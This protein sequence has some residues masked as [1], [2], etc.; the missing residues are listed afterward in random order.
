[1]AGC[2]NLCRFWL[3]ERHRLREVVLVGK[4]ELEELDIDWSPSLA[5]LIVSD[6][7]RLRDLYLCL[8]H[9]GTTSSEDSPAPVT[10]A[11]LVIDCPSLS[12]LHLAGWHELFAG[13]MD[14]AGAGGGGGS[15]RMPAVKQLRLGLPAEARP[16]N[17]DQMRRTIRGL[18]SL[19]R[20]EVPFALPPAPTPTRL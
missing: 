17:L 19:C 18:P 5:R 16:K 7:P 12:L 13:L 4:N 11:E 3:S 6:N 15:N 1:L 14:K 9:R 20:L 2:P 8:T 10:P